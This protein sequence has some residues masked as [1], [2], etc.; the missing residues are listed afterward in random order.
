MGTELTKDNMVDDLSRQM[1]TI[2]IAMVKA[3]NKRTDENNKFEEQ[4]QYVRNREWESAGKFM[5]MKDGQLTN[6]ITGVCEKGDKKEQ[7]TRKRKLLKRSKERD[8]SYRFNKRWRNF[9]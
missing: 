7:D 8:G 3:E 1:E 9:I 6:E 2:Y 5:N 4:L